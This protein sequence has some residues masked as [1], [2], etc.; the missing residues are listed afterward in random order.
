MFVRVKTTPN[1]PKKAIQIVES[2][3]RGKRI[4]QKII[5]H[6][7]YA[8]DDDELL[9]L[10]MLAESIKIK[11]EAGD[12][13]LLFPPEKLARLKKL[14][15][16]GKDSQY[17]INLKELIE[18]QRV[19]S[20][21]HDV[22]GALFERLGYRSVF[23]N[24]ARQKATVEIFKHIVLARIA[25][26]QSKMA[27]VDMLEEDFGVSLDL[28]R[29]YRMM[30]LLDDVAIEK[31]NDLTYQNT[32]DL[33]GSKIDIV[34]F[35]ATTIYFESFSGD[36]LRDMGFSKDLK[37][38]Q[39]QVL[40]GLMVNKE[41]LPIGYK[42]FPGSTYE[43]HTLMPT[44][45]DLR[46]RYHLDKVIFVADGGMFNRYNLEELEEEGFEYIVGARLRNLNN[47]LKEKVLDRKH[48][49]GEKD[50]CIAQFEYQDN[51]KLIVSYKESRA[52][53]DA[54]DRAKAIDKLRKRLD[55]VRN[56]KE[57]LSNYGYKRYLKVSGESQIELDE[58]KVEEDS[59]WDGLHG[60]VTNAKDLSNEEILHQ[61]INLWH[62]EEAFRITKHD[63]KVRPV[64]HW[65]ARRV[66]A[67]LAIC[68][69]A[70]ALVRHL[71]YRVRLQYKSLSIEKIRQCLIR[72]QTSVLF[73]V[74]KKIRFALP[75][76]ITQHA[77]KIYQVM[78]L[79][80]SLTP[81]IIK[82]VSGRSHG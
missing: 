72:V 24:P 31:L 71:E 13:H 67:H 25:N 69:T 40:F 76:R 28:H 27:S 4:S 77:K 47:Q 75:S 51:K 6:I 7:G 11:L 12:Q 30:D 68:F 20:G 14:E 21:I 22:Y 16:K 5:R 39:P 70:Y 29:V 54:L 35:D 3:R 81:W 73:H 56:P 34:F 36:E 9:K 78:N 23:K 82:L 49:R 59:R 42:V 33:F 2:V 80:R 1:S 8:T 10:K 37:F 60:V 15:I 53:K 65:T 46:K 26:P 50:F 61:Y 44:L 62:I 18:E 58:A 64:F 45:K 79:F 38:N 41:G 55:Q 74:E 48:Y 57:Y 52:Q 17:R 19:I 63:L 32:L 66:K 43:G